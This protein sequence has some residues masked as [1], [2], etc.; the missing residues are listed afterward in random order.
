MNGLPVRRLRLVAVALALS[1]NPAL[2]AAQHASITA[3]V[4]DSAGRPIHQAQVRVVGFAAGGLTNVAGTLALRDITPG[5][6]TLRV[7]RVG[8]EEQKRTIT[9]VA[10]ADATIE[11]HLIPVAF[12]LAPVVT[13]ATGEQRRVEVGNS[14]D[15]INAAQLVDVVPIRSVDDLLNSRTSSFVVTSGTQSGS[16]SR[17]RIRGP[18]SLSLSNQPIFIVDGIRINSSAADFAWLF[19]GPGTGGS[20]PSRLLDIAPEELETVEVIKG[21]SAAALFGTSAANGVV[22]MTTRRGNVGAPQW[23]TWLEAGVLDDR[24]AYPTAYTL[25]GKQPGQTA[26]A[27][28]LFCNLQRVGTGQCGIDSVAR[29]N[30]FSVD[31]LTPVARGS[32]VQYG[33]QV[34]GGTES[35]RYHLSA[36]REDETGVMKLPLFER[37]RFARENATLHDWTDRPNVLGKTNLRG[38]L[39]VVVSPTLDLALSS[40]MINLA[41]RY[42]LDSNATAG[43]GSQVFGGPGCIVC[44]PDRV[45]QSAAGQPPLNT[46]LFGYRAW[47]PG[48]TWQEK[49]E[50]GVDRFIVS[51]TANWRP[52]SWI[53]SRLTIGSDLTDRVDNNLVL[54]GEGPPITVTYRNGTAQV[55]HAN[56][57]STTVEWVGL[58]T[59]HPRQGVALRSSAGIQYVNSTLEISAASGRELPPGGQTPNGAVTRSGASLTTFSRTLGAFLEEAAAINDRLFLSVALR[60]DQ[61]NAFGTRFQHVYYPRASASWVISDEAFFPSSGWFDQFRVRIAYGTSGVQPLSN[62]AVAFYTASTQSLRG[63]D[64]SGLQAT[65][66]GNPDLRPERSSEWEGG[67]DA[68]LFGRRA[69]VQVT[70]YDKRTADALLSA[71]VAPS[72]GTANSIRDN[73]GAVRNS[74]WEFVVGG[75]PLDGRMVGLDVS[76]SWSTNRNMLLS[77]GGTPP[78]INEAN[79]SRVVEGYPL[80]GY[81]ERK[82]LSFSDRNGDGLIT[83]WPDT[84]KTEIVV[85]DSVLFLGSAAPRRLGSLTTGA[86]LWSGRV[87]VQ[88]HFDYRGGHFV[89]NGSE[90]IRCGSRSNCAGRMNP[91][92]PLDEQAAVIA[93]LEHPLRTNG[94]YI[95]PADAV[96]FRELSVQWIL[97]ERLS[98]SLFRSRRGSIVVSARN[99]KH[100]SRYRGVDPEADFR[101]SLDSDYGQELQTLGPVR[102]IVTRLNLVF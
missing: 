30:I 49:N 53:E 8:F 52:A 74:G 20:T 56:E 69:Q 12:S 60:T 45:V 94:G 90:R 25:F 29:L 79:A 68:L 65:S 61:N 43:L 89:Y 92:A 59:S 32:R 37:H 81:W 6:V 36:A 3:V 15:A 98:R 96:R 48:Y 4:K 5:L 75:R 42:S 19:P 77:L 46:P 13:T 22:V 17:M 88:T 10:G 76:V 16:G 28:F 82:I 11:F 34:G 100:W 7:L 62:D 26:E 27:A 41:Q 51:G 93:A 64:V 87:R 33:A 95:H 31:S 50:Q 44:S 57:R 102:Y 72:L 24:N 99:I 84:S 73:L 54:N 66:P 58:A 80:F 71:T 40:N 101:A 21:P 38:N 70:R 47:T 86:D 85:S 35:I 91:D 2:V 78:Q 23:R 63:T 1:G 97:S 14:V 83:Y 9:A 67:F 18:S 39:N 55:E